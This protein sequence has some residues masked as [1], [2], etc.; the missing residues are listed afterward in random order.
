MYTIIDKTKTCKNLS[1]SSIPTNFDFTGFAV[2]FLFNIR[3]DGKKKKK[4]AQCALT[5][6]ADPVVKRNMNMFTILY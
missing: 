1:F 3:K 5:A 2:V 4:S 6:K